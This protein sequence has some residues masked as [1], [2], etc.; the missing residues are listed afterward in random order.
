M[1]AGSTIYS[2]VL[3]EMSSKVYLVI[4]NILKCGDISST[5]WNDSN[6]YKKNDSGLVTFL[7]ES[8]ILL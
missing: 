5:C 2:N 8:V 3:H 4:S 1:L 7:L 6:G